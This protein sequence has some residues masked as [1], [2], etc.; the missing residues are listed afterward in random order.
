MSG[1]AKS[2]RLEPKSKRT[3]F[4]TAGTERG[5]VIVLNIRPLFAPKLDAA[6]SRFELIVFKIADMTIYATGK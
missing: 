4:A 2:A 5:A 3:E 1:V 6:S